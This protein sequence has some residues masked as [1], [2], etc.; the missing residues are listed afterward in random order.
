MKTIFKDKNITKIK[1]FL[2]LSDGTTVVHYTKFGYEKNY[3][4]LDDKEFGPFESVNLSVSLLGDQKRTIKDYYFTGRDF[5]GKTNFF[6]KEKQ[7]NVVKK[8]FQ[9]KDL[10]VIP[11]SET[12][13]QEDPWIRKD[14]EFI[15][16]ETGKQSFGPFKAIWEYQILDSEHYQFL[17]ILP[18]DENTLHYVINGKHITDIPL[19]APFSQTFTDFIP[20]LAPYCHLSYSESGKALLYEIPDNFMYI[21]GKKKDFFKGKCSDYVYSEKNGHILIRGKLNIMD[22]SALD[23]WYIYD[24]KLN[25]NWIKAK[26]LD[27]GTPVFTEVMQYINREWKELIWFCGNKQ[28]S[29]PFVVDDYESLILY[30][31]SLIYYLREG[32]SYIMMKGKEYQGFAV[33]DE[34]VVLLMDDEIKLYHHK[35]E[36]L[37]ETDLAQYLSEHNLLSGFDEIKLCVS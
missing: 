6:S 27:D 35:D 28:I 20:Y 24:G 8:R 32:T 16:F 34:Y 1:D 5:D 7:I 15:Y 17:Y 3:V 26:L 18:F 2:F 4:L 9:A 22:S 36:S 10:F 21:D 31:G 25:K 33:N 14:G 23:Y 19:E 11:E 12:S 29:V 37:S 30:G 13:K